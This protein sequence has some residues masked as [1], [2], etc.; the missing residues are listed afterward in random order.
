VV[1]A[2][3]GFHVDLRWSWF[4]HHKSRNKCIE[5]KIRC[6]WISPDQ[7]RWRSYKTTN[8]SSKTQ[9]QQATRT[10]DGPEKVEY[11]KLCVP[12]AAIMGPNDEPKIGKA[13]NG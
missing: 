9:T 6:I 5:K 4:H 12:L 10:E 3:G 13:K 7:I 8:Q 2:S 1:E 11:I